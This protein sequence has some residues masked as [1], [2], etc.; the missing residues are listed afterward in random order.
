MLATMS[1]WIASHR[2]APATIESG[3]GTDWAPLGPAG[4][5][6]TEDGLA[7]C[8]GK[9]HLYRRILRGFQEANMEFGVDVSRACLQGHWDDAL[10]RTHDLK[11]L[12]GTIGAHSLHKSSQALQSAIASRDQKAVSDLLPRVKS[13]LSSVLQEIDRLVTSE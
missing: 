4:P 10:R 1:E 9:T 12:A 5:I 13:D 7:R 11:G 3:P 6:D 2:P 8:L